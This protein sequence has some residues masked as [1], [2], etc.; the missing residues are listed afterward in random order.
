VTRTD[1]ALTVGELRSQL[2]HANDDAIV[3]VECEHESSVRFSH[4]ADSA[5][6]GSYE[7][8][9]MVRIRHDS[10][11]QVLDLLPEPEDDVD[12]DYEE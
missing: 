11:F 1:G 10:A 4:I 8:I 5:Y 3:T 9:S 2:A 7:G 6:V 12:E